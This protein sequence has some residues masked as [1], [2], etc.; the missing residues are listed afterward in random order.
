MRRSR[1]KIRRQPLRRRG[2]LDIGKTRENFAQHRLD[3]EACDMRAQAE[4][5]TAAESK[6][7]TGGAPD[8]LIDRDRKILIHRDL[9]IRNSMRHRKYVYVACFA[10][11][12]PSCHSRASALSGARGNPGVFDRLNR[13]E[14]I[15]SRFF[16]VSGWR[17]VASLIN[18]F[19]E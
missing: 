4:M 14:P 13:G 11:V 5:S 12:T 2:L 16:R 7:L 18:P 8:V 9:P 6:M 3:L 17:Q 10:T 15:V 1:D 19:S